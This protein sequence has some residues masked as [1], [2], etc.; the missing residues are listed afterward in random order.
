[1][2]LSNLSDSIDINQD[3]F[4]CPT[5]FEFSNYEALNVLDFLTSQVSQE[6]EDADFQGE[7]EVSIRRLNNSIRKPHKGKR[8]PPEK[9]TRKMLE[10]ENANKRYQTQYID[11]ATQKM[12]E[13]ANKKERSNSFADYGANEP[14][15]I[16]S[17]RPIRHLSQ[18]KII[19]QECHNE[20]TT[21]D[22]SDEL[23]QEQIENEIAFRI[24]GSDS[25]DE[26]VNHYSMIMTESFN[27][28][29]I[30]SC[31]T[32]MKSSNDGDQQC[33]DTRNIEEE[34]AINV[35]VQNTTDDDGN[36]TEKDAEPSEE[37]FSSEEENKETVRFS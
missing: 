34:T 21:S 9:P 32:G 4:Q 19:D 26:M 30:H 33:Y 22:K 24:D 17:C 23:V 31:N 11:L 3:N 20:R 13:Y 36:E 27:F 12:S 25:I 29:N 5:T 16:V 28:D 35:L 18:E 14:D 37:C 2:S 10:V 6:A 7:L 8:T 1:M 15:L